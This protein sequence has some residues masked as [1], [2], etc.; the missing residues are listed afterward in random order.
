MR[1]DRLG[2]LTVVLVSLWGLPLLAH[3]A[4]EADYDPDATRDLSGIVTKVDWVNPHAQVSITVEEDD[5]AVETWSIELG[6]PYALERGGWKRN[7]VDI[8]D[9]ITMENVA[10]AR[11]GTPR[12]GATRQSTLVLAD[13]ARMVLR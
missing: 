1:Y 4:F 5:G 9:A 10:L 8:G 11:D 7:T 13:G 3:H 12:A 6:P 2:L